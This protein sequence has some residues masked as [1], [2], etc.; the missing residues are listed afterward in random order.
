MT[1][2]QYYS[3]NSLTSEFKWTS[4]GKR[5]N[6]DELIN[7]PTKTEE[8]SRIQVSFR[9]QDA[10][11]RQAQ[12]GIP[13]VKNYSWSTIHC[14]FKIRQSARFTANIHNPCDF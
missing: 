10:N 5:N 9:T 1:T 2:T 3:N 7:I 12:S 14:V 8:R 11:I 6:L 4:V 13:D